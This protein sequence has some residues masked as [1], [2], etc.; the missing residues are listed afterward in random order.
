MNP[1]I[2]E[3]I[4]TA[5]ERNGRAME[6]RPAIGQKTAISKTRVVEGL[7]VETT[8]GRWTLVSDASEKSGG[9]AAAPDPGF[10]VRAA[11]GNCLAMGYIEWA[12]H[13]GVPIDG[14]E[15]EIQADFDVRGQHGAEDIPPGF[16][17]IRYHVR[18]ESSAPEADVRRVVE[19]A[20]ASSMVGD[21]FRRA[22][23]L[24]RHLAVVT[25]GAR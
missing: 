22:H 23:T 25:P 15:I 20:D 3:R 21:V 24:I 19:Q 2:I 11:L 14:V 18:I 10:A 7:R 17:E 13:L 4:K 6:L 16:S 1:E 5:F 8:E 9:G 12:A